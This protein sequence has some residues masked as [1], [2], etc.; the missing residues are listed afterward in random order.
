MELPVASSSGWHGRVGRQAQR[1]TRGTHRNLSG[2]SGLGRGGG[3]YGRDA[4][5]NASG[6]PRDS[7]RPTHDL[8]SYVPGLRESS[9]GRARA[10]AATPALEVPVMEAQR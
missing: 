1:I 9:W 6:R 8:K 3:W 7:G 4:L 2:V 5:V 10:G